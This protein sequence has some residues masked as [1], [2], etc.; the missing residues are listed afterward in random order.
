M[1]NSYGSPD[2][3]IA[4]IATPAGR[5]SVGVVRVS[6]NSVKQ[7]A[8]TLLG[9]VPKPRTAV[10][11]S[12]LDAKKQAIDEGIALYFPAP[13]SFTGEDILELQGHGGPVVMDMLLRAVL[14]LGVRLA[15]PGEFSERAFLNEKL[16]LAQAEAIA[17]LIESH[18]EQA[19]RCAAR[20]LQGEFSGQIHQL[21]EMVIEL[22]T[23]VEAALD[24]PEEEIDFLAD[25]ALL[26]R[27]EGCQRQLDS[28]MQKAQQGSL[29]R[30]G[31]RLV[32]AG[33]PNVGKSTLLNRLAGD[34]AAIVSDIPG[35]TRDVM[36]R[37][38]QVDG[39]PVKVIDTAGLRSSTD[40]IEQEGIRRAWSE[41]NAADL[42]L[43]LVDAS[44]GYAEPEHVIMRNMPK[45]IP[46]VRVWNK[47]DLVRKKPG[48]H[49]DEVFLSAKTGAG[50]DSLIERLKYQVGYRGY[51]EGVFLARRRHLEALESAAKA[52][53]QAID[54]LQTW[55]AGELVA[56]ELRTAQQALGEITGEF[57]SED[58]LGRIF[59]SFCIG[60]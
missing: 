44:S 16:D 27:L 55:H 12:F 23:H 25:S 11:R 49:D 59:A 40:P 1:R 41:I 50:I 60:K 13:H 32:I 20:S 22:R 8:N 17:D 36:H 2:D 24:F 5:G 30:E 21:V 43:L 26:K 35:T 38:I 33:C 58:L 29:L 31:M 3:T 53:A 28:V 4:A 52:M 42:L 15:R 48:L 54:Q 51:T 45:R 37:E 10:F 14:S 6:G 56:E 19:A 18:T 57:S 9:E 34:D 39:M 7:V 47:I 46:V